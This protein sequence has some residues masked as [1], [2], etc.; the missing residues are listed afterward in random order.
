[1]GTKIEYILEYILDKNGKPIF[2]KWFKKNQY[3]RKKKLEQIK[4]NNSKD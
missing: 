3:T 2:G 1:M 4:K